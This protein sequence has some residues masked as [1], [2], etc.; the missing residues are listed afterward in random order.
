MRIY[1]ITD[2]SDPSTLATYDPEGG[3][4]WTAVADRGFTVASDIGGGVLVLHNDRGRKRPPG[5]DGDAEN[6]SGPGPESHAGPD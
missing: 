6:G 3:F 4:Y 5:F 2:P 1:D